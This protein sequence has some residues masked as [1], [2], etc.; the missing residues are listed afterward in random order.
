M[1]DLAALLDVPEERCF[2]VFL[3]PEGQ[4]PSTASPKQPDWHRLSYRA[5]RR[6]QNTH[7]DT[8]T[9]TTALVAT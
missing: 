9:G 8:P 7:G 6:V 2:A 4:P 5:P 1:L 3:T